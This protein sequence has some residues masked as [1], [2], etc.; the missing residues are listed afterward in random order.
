MYNEVPNPL[1]FP[2]MEQDL[3][4]F[5]NEKK[6]FDQLREKNANGERWS[7]IDGPI[8]AN[9]PMGVHH[10]WGRTYKDVYQRYHAMLGHKLR[11][12]NGFDCQGLW[13][14]VEV[15]KELGFR[16]KKDVE[17]YGVE[18]FVR[19]CKSRVLNCAA[20]QT[21]QSIR[22]GYW[23]DWNNPEELKML[24]DTLMEDPQKEVT[25]QGPGGPVTGT[26]EAVVGRLGLEGIEGSYFTFSDENNY[27]IWALLKKMF[28]EGRIYKGND[29]V[30]WSGRSGT[31]YSQMEIIEGRKLVA[32]RAIFVRF[33]LKGKD[34]EYLL[35]WTTT[36]WTLTSNVAAAVNVNL[37]YVKLRASDGS[38]Y[39]FAKDNL[40]FKRLDKQYKE[41]KQ[42]VDGVP[43]LKTLAQVF[44]ERG[45]FE[46]EDTVKGADMVGWEYE[47]PFD[48]FPAQSTMGGHP[49]AND[50][51]AEKGVNGINCHRVIDGGKDNIGND[52][53]VAGE[54]TGIVHIAPGCGDID[55]KI[56]Q[57]QG[58]VDIAP[59]NDEAR[60]VEG[61]DW[62]TGELATDHDIAT[63]I[64]DD[65]K[66][67]EFLVHVEKY[68][69]V[70]PHCWRSGDELVYRIVDEWYIQMDWRDRIKK[71][72]DDIRWI[73]AWGQDR[74]HE[75]L[76]NM[77]DWMISK[78]RFWGLALPIW[79]FE[80]GSFFVIGSLEELKE[81][82]CE[83]WEE[84]EGHS[85]HRPWIDKVKIKHPET[86]LVGTRIPDVGNPWLDAGIVPFSTMRYNTDRSYW[87]QWFPGDFVT[88]CFP[89][90]FRNWFYSLLAMATALED[91]AP[92][93]TLLGHALVRDEN[94]K[95]MHKSTGN[96]IEFNTAASKIGADVM[97]WMYAGQNPASNLN[98]GFGPAGETRRKLA[99]LWNT[100]AFFVTYARTDE[101]K[102]TEGEMPLDQRSALDRWILALLQELIETAH[103]CYSNYAV[104]DLIKASEK[105]FD[106]LSNWYLRT[107]R[108]RFWREGDD[109]D[110]LAAFQTMHEV[111]TAVSKILAPVLPFLCD[112]MY[113]NLVV[114][115][116]PDAPQSVHLC[117]FPKVDESLVNKEL[118]EKMEVVVRIVELGRSIRKEHKLRVRLPLQ[119][120]SVACRKEEEKSWLPDFASQITDELNI[121]ELVFI[122]DPAD[123]VTYKIKPN[124]RLLG[125]KFG[126]NMPQVGKALNSLDPREVASKARA[127]EAIQVEVA[128]EARELT[129]E[130]LDVQM[131]AAEG[132]AVAEESGYIVALST[133]LTPEL[134]REGISRDIIRALN[135]LRREADY[136][137]SDRITVQWCSEDPEVQKALK[138]HAESIMQEVL[139]TQMDSAD[140]P[141][142]D[143]TQ[144]LELEDDAKIVLAV[145]KNFLDP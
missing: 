39:Y 82:A 29:V 21:E 59:L 16:T 94:G 30:P 26:A 120:I 35:V 121:K 9:N 53:V 40:E 143:A 91:R 23:M 45:G 15:E 83:G 89:G 64:I 115:I 106:R 14:E 139:A 97:R 70:Y 130:E 95:E 76:D 133:D 110:K 132:L 74:E 2:S 60:Y 62:L 24:A 77:G 66:E 101:F 86:G 136:Q 131:D 79:T 10:A 85:P 34:K 13:V 17:E 19:K 55:H 65:L 61:F 63:K 47:G 3:L 98:F 114:T 18:K 90:Q 144:E 93:K 137:V 28:E 134:L 105:F 22:L 4:S 56:G 129:S 72:V 119:T 100:Y 80:D 141:S 50:D 113:R 27:T 87:E 11:Y 36:P 111:L 46:V 25:I 7:F 138:E 41:K 92:F 140:S 81:L 103:D 78:K 49:E 108:E 109:P 127:G 33:P 84:F 48:H 145:L 52:N 43:K 57:K 107:G 126:K 128:G 71:V 123:L 6:V 37:D 102:P 1:D 75:W 142:G 68:P 44:K 124:F 31:S 122:D 117:D 69:H 12:Q 135:N 54:G 5:W 125:P 104:S 38:A 42:W 88:E 96:S 73:P 67:R 32:H 116:D 118:L 58:L 8:T 112:A 20:I 51:L 99:T